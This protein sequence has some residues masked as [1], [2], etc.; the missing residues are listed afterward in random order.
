MTTIVIKFGKFRFNRLPMVMCASVNIF[1][2][3]V[4]ELLGDTEAG[5]MY[6]NDIIVFS[7]NCFRK[8]IN[9]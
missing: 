9:S 1:Q 5:K 2:S 4:D 8:H 6:I 3:K 7:K